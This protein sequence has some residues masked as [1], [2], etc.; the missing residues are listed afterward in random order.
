MPETFWSAPSLEPRRN[1]KFLV[2]LNRIPTWVVKNVNLPSITVAEGSHKFLNHTFYFP[3]TVEYNEVSVTVVD[4][5]DKD[6]SKNILENFSNS[7]YTTPDTV[8]NAETSLLTKAG[9]VNAFGEVILKQLGG[10]DDGQTNTL[11]FDLINA[12]I[13]VVEFPQSL[14]YDNSD[15]SEVKITFRYDYFRASADSDTL[16]A[17]GGSK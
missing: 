9:S 1:F 11:Q 8:D 12:W 17:F 4:A 6:I 13:K 2:T 15:A 3:G 7:G 16:G 5:I 10:G 14:S